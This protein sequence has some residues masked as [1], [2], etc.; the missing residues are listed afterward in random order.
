MSD[1]QPTQ[2]TIVTT[3]IRYFIMALLLTL[4]IALPVA[5]NEAPDVM[6]ANFYRQHEDVTQF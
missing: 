3:P 1:Y 2:R 5:A 6:L 4:A